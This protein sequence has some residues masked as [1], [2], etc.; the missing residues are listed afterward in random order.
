MRFYVQSLGHRAWW[1]QLKIQLYAMG[2]SQLFADWE[3]S[4]GQMIYLFGASP[5]EA[6]SLLVE[7]RA[8]I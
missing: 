4:L 1:D 8:K 6:A 3:K 7:E 2:Q 5:R